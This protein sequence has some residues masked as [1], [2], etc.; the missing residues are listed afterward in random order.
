MFEISINTE[1]IDFSFLGK[2]NI[3]PGKVF[4]Y[5]NAPI[6]LPTQINKDPW[7]YGRNR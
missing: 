4:G 3:G 6:F 2:L 1:L 5:S 7:W